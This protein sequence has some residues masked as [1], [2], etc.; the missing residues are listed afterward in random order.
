M[1]NNITN[2]LNSETISSA[3]LSYIIKT[4]KMKTRLTGF[5]SRTENATETSFYFAEGLLTDDNGDGGDAFVGETVTGINKK[6]A[7]ESF[8]SR[9]WREYIEN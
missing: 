9:A 3:D 5:V 7:G 6:T 1:N 8:F 4:P 2:N